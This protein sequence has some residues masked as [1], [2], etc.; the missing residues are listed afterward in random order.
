MK[1][2]RLVSAHK[3]L[4][5]D[6]LSDFYNAIWQAWNTYIIAKKNQVLPPS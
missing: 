1:H 5:A 6:A 4:R 2:I 3:A